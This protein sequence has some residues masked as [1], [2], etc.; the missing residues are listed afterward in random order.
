[1]ITTYL[2]RRFLVL[3]VVILAL[4]LGFGNQVSAQTPV[5]I[6]VNSSLSGKV[7]DEVTLTFSVSNLTGL[8]LIGFITEVRFDT[9][10]IAIRAEDI[11][12][13]NIDLPSYAASVGPASFG[14]NAASGS[15]G[16]LSGSGILFTV[17]GK[18]KKNGYNPEGLSIRRFKLGDY[19]PTTPSISRS[20]ND[21]TPVNIPLLV[22]SASLSVPNV[23]GPAWQRMEIPVTLTNRDSVNV[24]SF[25]FD[26]I[27]S[28][29]L[30]PA[31]GL[32]VSGTLADTSSVTITEL[33]NGYR[34]EGNAQ[35]NS[36]VSDTLIKISAIP[37][38]V[39]ASTPYAIQNITVRTPELVA[40]PLSNVSGTISVTAD[41]SNIAPSFSTTFSDTT[42]AVAQTLS[43]VFTAQDPNSDVLTFG[44]SGAPTGASIHPTT[45]LFEWTPLSTQVGKFNFTVTV[46]DGRITQPIEHPVTITVRA[47]LTNSIP[48]FT[49][50]FTDTTISVEQSLSFVFSAVDADLDPITFGLT[51]APTGATIHPTTGTFDWTP[52]SSQ[53]G[54]F[55]FNV[56]ITDGFVSEPVARPV[57]IT[58]LPPPV[59]VTFRVHMELATFNPESQQLYFSGSNVGWS[60]PG[61]NLSLLLNPSTQSLVY[62]STQMIIPD[63]VR[64]KFYITGGGLTGTGGEEWVGE[65]NRMMV[66]SRDTTITLIFG[67]QPD[68]VVELDRVRFLG[69]GAPVRV[70]GLVTTPNLASTG[71]SV[72]VQDATA[73]IKINWPS[74]SPGSTTNPFKAGTRIQLDASTEVTSG[75]RELRPSSATILAEN[76][77][78]PT[79]V[80]LTQRSQFGLTSSLQ[81]MRITMA[82]MKLST[83]APWPT[84]MGSIGVAFPTQMTGYFPTSVFADTSLT[85]HIARGVSELDGSVRPGG[86]FNLSGV[87]GRHNQTTVL[88]PFYASEL[89]TATSVIELDSDIPLSYG[90]DGNFP[91]PFNPSTVIRFRVPEAGH[92][93]VEVFNV[94][95]Q[96]VAVLLESPMAPGVHSVTLDAGSLASGMYMIRVRS[97]AWVG[98][99]KVLLMK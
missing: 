3:N 29:S 81:G 84:S 54:T 71:A 23:S 56:T 34:V 53:I 13:G 66:V 41:V 14:I 52:L 15:S 49:S 68:E 73:G 55:N 74:F 17:K 87:L 72:Y 31:D 44:I 62:T 20:L 21:N 1:V 93:S 91:N 30:Y 9:S 65:P 45:G 4:F 86:A 38:T 98:V 25:Q 89:T 24:G 50:A 64:Y 16:F 28:K 7:N 22:S 95:G 75:E 19:Y 82:D 33:I 88:W 60:I 83:D 59:N 2:Y 43:F 67:V 46:T 90:I 40:L 58:V 35:S 27:V 18:L 92:T 47:G 42:T 57:T 51:G 76:Q 48:T 85:I 39:V 36:L 6:T 99:H 10:M 77:T 37:K 11:F 94:M 26:V 97:G 5:Q 61:S 96:R 63:T 12:K 80:V 70:I 32:R 8:S 78:L 79:P 69:D